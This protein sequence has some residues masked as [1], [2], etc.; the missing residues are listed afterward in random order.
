MTFHP[1]ILIKLSLSIFNLKTG[2]H[3]FLFRS[4]P[5]TANTKRY[6]TTES[7]EVE[8]GA[9]LGGKYS[10]LLYTAGTGFQ[11]LELLV[12]SHSYN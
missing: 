2:I 11:E 7:A 8:L 3:C 6:R 10:P 1:A 9:I 12:F 5:P 4:V